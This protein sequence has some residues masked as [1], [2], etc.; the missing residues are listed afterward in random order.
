[1]LLGSNPSFT[2]C[3]SVNPVKSTTT[4]SNITIRNHRK[5]N[6]RQLWY[7]WIPKYFFFYY[8]W[9]LQINPT[10]LVYERPNRV[11]KKDAYFCWFREVSV[12][13][14]YVG[15]ISK[16]PI[17]N[18]NVIHYHS[19]HIVLKLSV[20]GL[21]ISYLKATRHSTLCVDFLRVHQRFW[22]THMK[23]YHQCRQQYQYHQ[24]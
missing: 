23:C 19:A 5:K 7:M 6:E 1:M 24:Q 15:F 13:E 12:C 21:N 4:H 3:R 17:Q 11:T 9:I 18:A 20:G 14:T 10:N 16:F 22:I 2:K 8:N